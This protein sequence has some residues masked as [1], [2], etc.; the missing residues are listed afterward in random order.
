MSATVSA[1]VD[2]CLLFAMAGGSLSQKSAGWLAEGLGGILLYQPNIQ[3]AGQLR[4]LCD[5][6]RAAGTDVLI[7]VNAEG[8]ELTPMHPDGVLPHPGHLALGA[9]DDT[10]LTEAVAA[11][12]GNELARA[13]INLNL[14]PVADIR[15]LPDNPLV[16]IR[17]FGA[18]AGLVARHAAAYIRGLQSTGVAAA[19]KHFPGFGSAWATSDLTFPVVAGDLDEALR[20]FAAA[21][22]SAVPAILTSHAIYPACGP[23]PAT[24]S[25]E[26]LVGLLRERLGF[27]GVIIGDSLTMSAVIAQ[28][29]AA[30]A[31]VRALNAGVDLLC[32]TGGFVEQRAVRD[33]IVAAAVSG[34]IAE[35]RLAE[36]ANR[37]RCL[38]RAHARPTGAQVP[39]PEWPAGLARG[40]LYIDAPLPLR[41]SPYVLEFPENRRGGEPGAASLLT[42]LKELDPGVSGLRLSSTGAALAYAVRAAPP[43]RPLLLLA[44]DAHR[45]QWLSGN[46]SAILDLRK[47][48]ILVG[49]GTTSDA[50]LAEGRYL[51]TRGSAEPNLRA[52]ALSLLGRA[53]S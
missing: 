38:A 9:L 32:M 18:D 35:S 31:G 46:L 47:D 37:V 8:G 1:L 21:I 40:L 44:R 42:V 4:T 2:R 6:I 13:G 39:V 3:D 20:P 49:L 29:G 5:Q 36:A 45:D 33:Y 27:D 48:A 23:H 51:G 14:A 52:A 53:G 25:R 15:A 11:D 10:A 17:S 12:I 34:R 28:L 16:G 22:G 43:D 26:I 30:E 50:G 24:L 41:G 7:A 19:A